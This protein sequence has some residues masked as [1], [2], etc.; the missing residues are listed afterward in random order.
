MSE[1]IKDSSSLTLEKERKVAITG[2]D[3]MAALDFWRHFNIPIPPELETA[4][5]NFTNDP[6][7]EN[8]CFVTLEVCK[9]IAF[10]DHPAFKDEMFKQ[11]V[12]ETSGVTY[13]ML[14]DKQLEES[15]AENK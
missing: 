3:A 11:I 1:E 4:I 7:Y 8:Q 10:T 14:F 5:T 6:T 13:D 9:A 12:E 2:E 15:L